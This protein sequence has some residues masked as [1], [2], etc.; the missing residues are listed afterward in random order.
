MQYKRDVIEAKLRERIKEKYGDQHNF[1]LVMFIPVRDKH[2]YYE[3]PILI[4]VD[5]EFNEVVH[6]IPVWDLVP[7][8]YEDITI[9]VDS[10]NFKY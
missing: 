8:E 5:S 4:I 9:N 2:G 1:K 10:L 7:G 6:N 3:E